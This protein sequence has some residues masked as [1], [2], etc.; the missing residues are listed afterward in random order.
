MRTLKGIG[1]FVVIICP[2]VIMMLLSF[3]VGFISNHVVIGFWR[4]FYYADT[5]FQGVIDKFVDTLPN[6]KK[7]EQVNAL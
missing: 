3:C 6:S 2:T 4:G 5:E 7:G 1:L